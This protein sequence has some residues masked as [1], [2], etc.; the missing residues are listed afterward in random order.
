MAVW[1]INTNISLFKPLGCSFFP[2]QEDRTAYIDRRI[3]AYDNSQ[4]QGQS[5]IMYHFSSNE[6]NDQK[7]EQDSDSGDE[8]SA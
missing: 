6:N 7:G 5:E 2:F 8:G 3:S 4:K 1:K